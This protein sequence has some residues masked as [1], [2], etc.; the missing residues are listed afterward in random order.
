MIHYR[1]PPAIKAFPKEPWRHKVGINISCHFIIK[2]YVNRKIMS[3][4]LWIF[5]KSICLHVKHLIALAKRE[6]V[7]IVFI[8]NSLSYA[9][10]YMNHYPQQQKTTT[11]TK[12]K[13]Q[14][15]N[16]G[17]CAQQKEKSTCMH[18]TS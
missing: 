18:K 12:T 11:K 10:Q 3:Y 15:T 13:K 16:T 14:K 7:R 17:K 5:T 4:I 8:C 9:C 1:I 2:N 6:S